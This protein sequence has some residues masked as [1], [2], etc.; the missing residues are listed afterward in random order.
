MVK[1][2][3]EH[4]ITNKRVLLRVDFNVTLT[5]GFKIADDERIKQSLPTI[6]NLL[7]GNNRLILVA[8]LNRPKKRDKK[9]SFK[10]AAKRLQE[11]LTQNKVIFVDDFLSEKGRDQIENQKKGQVVFLENIRFYEGETKNDREFSRNLSSIADVYVDDA[12]GNCHRTH[13]SMVGVAEFLPSYGGI[14][15]KKEIEVI[16]HLLK[17][18]RH[19]FVA[20]IGGSKIS[21]KFELLHKLTEI[22][23]VMVL[24]GGIANTFLDAKDLPIGRSLYEKGMEGEVKQ[25]IREAK[26]HGTEI[27]LPE[28]V[29]VG[30]K[31]NNENGGEVRK[32]ENVRVKDVILDVGPETMAQYGRIVM[33]AR[34]IIWNGPVGYIE[35]EQFKRG[36]DFLY[37]SMAHN[38]DVTSIVGGGD[39]IA[40]ISKK[41]YL[42]N[43]T[44]ISTGG[45]AMLEFIEKGT[46]PGIKALE[47]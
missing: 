1:F 33:T 21:T 13:A 11:Y 20:I 30:E 35:N 29:A 28:D 8:H 6:K 26:K 34:T 46:L 17:R 32:V 2:I 14:L 19:P 24:G 3:D 18:P 22:S 5:A 47:G 36:T 38:G 45:G 15:L 27:V 25:I 16:G 9:H 37:Y 7:K 10:V 43:I 41:E 42:D 23:D 44:H 12:F 40:A 31:N 4:K 39:T